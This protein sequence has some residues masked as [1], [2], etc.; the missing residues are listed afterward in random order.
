MTLRRSTGAH[1][2]WVGVQHSAPGMLI[3][4]GHAAT[5]LSKAIEWVPALFTVPAISVPWRPV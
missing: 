3:S 2:A 5:V 1:Q 4:V